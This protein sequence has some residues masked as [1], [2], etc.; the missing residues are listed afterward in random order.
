[1]IATL[2]ALVMQLAGAGAGAAFAAD[3]PTITWAASP[4]NEAGPDGRTW[5]ELE[6]DPGESTIDHLA[7]RNLGAEEITFTLTAADGYLTS[8]GRFNMLPSDQDSTDAGTWIDVAE[9]VT[10]PPAG[11][12]IVPFT[13]KVP[14]NATPGD[15]AAGI[16][17][18]VYSVNA[19]ETGTRLGVESRIGF[20]VMTRVSGELRPALNVAAISAGY[21]LSWN[22]FAPGAIDVTTELE[23]SG[24][25][26]LEVPVSTA[27]SGTQSGSEE[28]GAPDPVQLLPGDRRSTI[29]H[30]S[31]VWPLGFAIVPVEFRPMVVEPDGGV[32]PM[33]PISQDIFVWTMPWPHL[34]ILLAGALIVCALLLGRRR[35]AREVER[36]VR[37][38]QERGR[39][40]ALANGAPVETGVP[41][42]T[43]A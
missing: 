5:V 40:E 18:S 37:D 31:E 24:N 35:Q 9:T 1:M 8:T 22:P 27:E 34:L 30:V 41:A 21:D 3:D 19:S 28:S 12:E 17:A 36:L 10:V 13:V 32:E 42:E 14:A 2:A 29:V 25:V 20:R 15:H 38:A 26:R 11:T 33:A 16:A 39:R 4:A 7:V 6:L 23:N 43:G